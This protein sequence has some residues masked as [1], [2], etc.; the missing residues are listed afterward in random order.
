MTTR[1]TARP[2]RHPGATCVGLAYVCIFLR[3]RD[4]A[5]ADASVKLLD[6]IAKQVHLQLVGQSGRASPPPLSLSSA[7]ICAFDDSAR[8][9]ACSLKGG[10]A[11]GIVGI[12][13][14]GGQL[15]IPFI[16]ARDEE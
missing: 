8:G 5:A 16:D 15:Q 12:D 9:H 4:A 1:R 11:I 7:R 6:A 14:G 10:E 3:K 2:S 13:G